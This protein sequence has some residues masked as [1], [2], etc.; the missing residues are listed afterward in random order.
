M[1]P[2]VQ[3]GSFAGTFPL[4]LATGRPILGR[5]FVKPDGTDL[6]LP[7]GVTDSVETT[8][9]GD[10]ED[11]RIINLG[12]DFDQILIV[13]E[14]PFGGNN[15]HPALAYALGTA[16]GVIIQIGGSFMNHISQTSAGAYFQGKLTG[17]DANKIKLGSSGSTP[18]GFNDGGNT[19]HLIGLKLA[20]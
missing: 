4:D 8:W 6:Y 12:D 19:Y 15:S 2:A 11:N 20:A 18:F 5:K 13:V 10:D 9:E 1:P 17:V 14:E 7:A 16:F 3:S